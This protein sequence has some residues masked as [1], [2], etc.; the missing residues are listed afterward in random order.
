MTQKAQNL[1]GIVFD[2]DGTLFDYAHV[3][4]EV[5]SET[6]ATAFAEMG[7]GTAEHKRAQQAMLT[8][9]GIDNEGNSLAKGL[10]FT[11]KRHLILKRYLLYC[12]RY[13]I[14]A[15]KAFRLYQQNIK[16]SE[17]LVSKHLQN[18]DFTVQ[19]NLFSKLKERGYYI[20][21]ITSDT[22]T[23]S[24]N[25]LSIMGLEGMVDFLSTR[26]SSYHR[27]PHPQAFKAFCSRFN[28]DSHEVAIVGDTE[29]DMKMAKKGKAGYTIAVLSGSNDEKLLKRM[30]SVIY[31]D[32]SYLEHDPRL[33]PPLHSSTTSHL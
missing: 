7:K 25:F 22:E 32:I 26:D 9:M 27:K 3:W 33:F 10:V 1:K 11:H 21:I 8:L 6:V 29:T 20:G 5:L 24:K 12:I 13:R 18:L 4:A 14:N 19:Q 2:K 23:S 30:A 31:K 17:D 28:L 16:H 15:V